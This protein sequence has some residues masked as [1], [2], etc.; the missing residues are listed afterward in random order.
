MILGLELG[1]G[2]LFK[3]RA[4]TRA[5]STRV[6]VIIRAKSRVWVRAI[7]RVIKRTRHIG[8]SDYI[9]Q[10]RNNERTHRSLVNND[11]KS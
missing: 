3:L 9:E 4:T 6:R 5:R 11:R 10:T 1:L 8:K 7:L 2:L